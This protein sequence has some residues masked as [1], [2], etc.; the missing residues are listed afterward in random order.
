MFRYFYLPYSYLDSSITLWLQLLVRQKLISHS[1]RQG[2]SCSQHLLPLTKS[3]LHC[4][5]MSLSSSSSSSSSV[6]CWW[7]LPAFL[8]AC[9]T[10]LL[11]PALTL[12]QSHVLNVSQTW[13]SVSCVT[14]T[15]WKM[16]VCATLAVLNVKRHCYESSMSLI[17]VCALNVFQAAA[18]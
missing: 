16:C 11:M 7:Y 14:L 10:L 6:L 15:L 12:I 2:Q 1:G 17:N 18:G 9:A 5:P 3:A 13:S 4:S 8:P